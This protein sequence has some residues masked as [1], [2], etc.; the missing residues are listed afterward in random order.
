MAVLA[1]GN[2]VFAV[3]IELA[4]DESAFQAVKRMIPFIQPYRILYEQKS[5]VGE[6]R[7]A[8]GGGE[9][10][11]LEEHYT[12][13]WLCYSE[14]SHETGQVAQDLDINVL[15]KSGNDQSS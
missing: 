2:L 3:D 7:R 8:K 1:V 5:F 12:I 4:T 10:Q 9:I 11:R 15:K 14:K 6:K 13:S